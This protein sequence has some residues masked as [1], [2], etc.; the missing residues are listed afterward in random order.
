MERSK[1]FFDDLILWIDYDYVPYPLFGSQDDE[2]PK[3]LLERL[4][5]KRLLLLCKTSLK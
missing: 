3:F 5:K 2:H 4:L 1:C